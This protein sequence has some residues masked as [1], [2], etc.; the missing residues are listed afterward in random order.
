MPTQPGRKRFVVQE[1]RGRSLHY[2]FRLEAGGVLKSWAVPKG[3]SADPRQKRLAVRQPDHP[4]DYA[5]FEGVIPSGEYGAGPVIVWDTGTYRNQ[6]VQDGKTVPVEEAI[7]RGHV[8]FALDGKKLHGGYALTRVGN[9]KGDDWLLVKADDDDADRTHD[10][11]RDEPRSVV[12]GRTLEDLEKA[13]GPEVHPADSPLTRLSPAARER[14]VPAPPPTWVQPMLATLTKKRFSDPAWIFERKLDG[15]RCL[16]FRA[17][18]AVRLLS[19]N[20]KVLNEHYPEIAD[21]LARQPGPDLVVDG[22]IVAFS[23]GETNF[24]RL[25]HRMQVADPGQARRTG[26]TVFHYLFDI[27][28]LDGFDLTALGLRDRK[29][30]LRASISFGGPLRYT[31]HRNA[32]GEAYYKHACQSGW[33]GV[34]AKLA[35]GPYVHARSMDWLKFKCQAGQEFVIG[36]FT[37]PRRSREGFG[38]LLIGYY[39]GND[40]VYAGKV[41]TGFDEQTLQDLRHR[42]D[43]LEVERTPFSIGDPPRGAH[44]VRPELVGDVRFSQW[45]ADGRLRHP[46][47][48]GL[49]DDKDAREVFREEA[50]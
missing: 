50:V 35:D 24:S 28:Y 49:R 34:M 27:V 9:W 46:A 25:E 15:E 14:L 18:G 31:P 17:G 6:T 29:R 20:R 4:L 40:F 47:F 30:L 3:P 42:L 11:E 26:I 43:A 32:T 16:A 2:D 23:G 41:G 33:E 1:H 48:L 7:E 36:G 8:R 10:L 44:W 37:D 12:S 19:R 39:R 22:E 38:A 45:T 5:T 21:A 13:K